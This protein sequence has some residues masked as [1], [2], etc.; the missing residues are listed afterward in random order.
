MEP[1]FPDGYSKGISDLGDVP[2]GTQGYFYSG[3]TM[4]I[5]IVWPGIQ[6]SAYRSDIKKEY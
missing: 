2:S 5:Y 1:N 4:K 3:K 6:R